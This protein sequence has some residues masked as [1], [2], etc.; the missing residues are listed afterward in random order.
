MQLEDEVRVGMKSPRCCSIPLAVVKI[1]I[2][3][4]SVHIS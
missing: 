3:A 4:I 2:G 1:I